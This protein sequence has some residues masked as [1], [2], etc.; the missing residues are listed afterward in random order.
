MTNKELDIVINNIEEMVE[1][2]DSNAYETLIAY[3]NS[4]INE[5]RVT[6]AVNLADFDE[7]IAIPTLINFIENDLSKE[8]RIEALES[9]STFKSITVYNSLKNYSLI[10][11]APRR[12]H[13]IIARGL[14]FYPSSESIKILERYLMNS[15]DHVV[16][17]FAVDSLKNINNYLMK[18][19]W[20]KLANHQHH[21]VQKVANE[22]LSNI[23]WISSSQI[24]QIKDIVQKKSLTLKGFFYE[25]FPAR[26]VKDTFQLNMEEELL[27]N[28]FNHIYIDSHNNNNK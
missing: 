10:Q 1:H 24:N 28:T 2:Q 13:Q 3:K 18:E 9:L 27:F 5:L 23:N 12:F 22:L 6:V 20:Q 14:E 7:H 21:Y 16:W 17:I 11:D 26:I 15:N 8:V 4:D 19:L 25:K